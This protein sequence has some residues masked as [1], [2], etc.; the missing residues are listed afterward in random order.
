MGHRSLGIALGNRAMQVAEMD[1]TSSGHHLVH[2]AEFQFGEPDSLQEPSAL[3]QKLAQFLKQHGFS[4]SQTVIGLPAQWLMLKEKTLPPASAEMLNNMLLI[5]AERDFSLELADLTLDYVPG[6]ETGEGRAVMLVAVLRERIQQIRS[7]ADAAGLKLQAITATTLALANASRKDQVLHFGTNGVELATCDSDGLPRLCHVAPGSVF[8][9]PEGRPAAVQLAGELRRVLALTQRSA[10]AAG[11]QVWDDTGVAAA[12]IRDLAL[13][14]GM[15]L[16]LGE[17]FEG[18]AVEGLGSAH[19]AAVAAVALCQFHPKLAPVD[20]LH[21]RLA[22]KPPAKLSSRAIWGAVAAVALLSGAAYMLFDW[23]QSA[24]EVAELR[25]KR[26]EMKEQIGTAKSFIERVNATRTWYDRRP[27]YLECLRTIT[28][29]FP[30]EGRAWTS[31]LS[32]REDMRGILNGRAVDEKSVLD[33]L[34]Q[35]KSSRALAG[36]KLLQM[37]GS[38]TKNAEITFGISF[39]FRGTEQR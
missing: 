26:D 6:R 1:A 33:V 22:V 7:L 17:H 28:L 39:A 29:C 23:H 8:N 31:N 5:Q 19:A 27:N 14:L 21:S 30:V 32:L 9:N 16:S 10:G 37:R 11:M 25:Q 36:V 34:D 12:L 20:L 38:G 3:G 15:P 35:M 4:A 18:V 13:E 24:V 2:V